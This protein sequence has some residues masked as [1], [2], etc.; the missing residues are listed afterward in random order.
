MIL[1]FHPCFI[2]DA[3]IIPGARRLEPSDFSLIKGAE[4]ILLPQT[5]SLALYRACRAS[6]ALLFPNYAL[7]FQY[8]GKTGQS[9]LFEKMSW[10]HPQTRRWRSIGAFSGKPMPETPFFIKAD[11]SH[12][13]SGVWLI[14]NRGELDFALKRLE[15]WDRSPFLTQKLI[16]SGGNVLRVVVLGRRFFCYWKRPQGP[17]RMVTTISRGARIDKRWRADLRAKGVIQAKKMCEASGID[18]AAM[19]FVFAMTDPDP[20]P[21]VLE[22]NYFFGRRGLG[23]SLNY[24]RILYNAVREWLEEHGIDPKPLKLV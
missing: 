7:R 14:R 4:A 6:S 3:Q 5:C 13:G 21:L 23:G 1:S 9:R 8:P 15:A 22:I 24:Y 16:S 12:E 11:R 20:Q 19:D 17:E 10:P 18:L 2:A